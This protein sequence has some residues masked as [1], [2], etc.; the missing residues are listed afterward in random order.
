VNHCRVQ[1][2]R[3]ELSEQGLGVRRLVVAEE[4][5]AGLLARQPDRQRLEAGVIT[6]MKVSRVPGDTADVLAISVAKA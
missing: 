3:R 2:H 4:D 5:D 1:R 6:G